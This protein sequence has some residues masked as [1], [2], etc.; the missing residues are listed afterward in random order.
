MQH[1]ILRVKSQKAV[2]NPKWVL[3]RLKIYN[4][5]FKGW[6]IDRILSQKFHKVYLLEKRWNKKPVVYYIVVT[7]GYFSFVRGITDIS[8]RFCAP[9]WGV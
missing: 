9:Y 2:I 5:V 6:Y 3:T 1:V 8:E 7:V 4:V